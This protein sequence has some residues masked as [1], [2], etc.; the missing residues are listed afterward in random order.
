MDIGSVTGSNKL[1]HIF[2]AFPKKKIPYFVN[3]KGQQIASSQVQMYHREALRS[4]QS[5][6]GFQPLWSCYKW[7]NF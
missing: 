6:F 7:N 4:L 1:F 5:K 2:W 3:K